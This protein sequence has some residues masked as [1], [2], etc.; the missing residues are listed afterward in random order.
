MGLAA[1]GAFASNA[2]AN[3][4]SAGLVVPFPAG[5]GGDVLARSVAGALA[6]ELGTKIWVDNRPGAGGTIGA[7]HLSRARADGSMLGYVTN[8]IL[9]VNPLLYPNVPFNPREELRPVGMI[10]EIGLVGVL[11]P[12]AI[13]GVTDLKS[14]VAWAKAHPKEVN[15]AS[16]GI[17]TTSHLAGLLFARRAGLEL[18]HV[19]YR[20]GA[21]A[22]LDVLSGRIPFMIDVAPNALQHVRSG[23]LT[24]LGSASRK[25]LEIA[26][27]IPTFAEAGVAGVE[28]SAWDGIVLPK[29]ASDELVNRVSAAL[30]R[31]LKRPEVVASLSKKGA[32]PRPGTSADFIRFIESETPKW[33]EL[34]E[35][36]QA[37]ASK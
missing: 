27:D 20:G 4:E 5:G 29:G 10:S 26:P 31:A 9:C 14:L 21:A 19:P 22:M 18:T 17:G 6:E 34:V 16:S 11:N 25:R 37:E 12:N 13:K 15:F 32:E 33:A 3:T 23:K 2:F 28:L 24:A 1:S 36:V 35:A 8:G 7:R 30:A